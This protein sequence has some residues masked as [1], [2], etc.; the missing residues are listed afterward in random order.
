MCLLL[1]ALLLK[2]RK[3]RGQSGQG[4]VTQPHCYCHRLLARS[5][6]GEGERASTSPVSRAWFSNQ[7]GA[8]LATARRSHR[9]FYYYYQWLGQQQKWSR[10]KAKHAV[11]HT[12]TAQSYTRMT[13]LVRALSVT[14]AGFPSLTE[15]K[16]WLGLLV[17]NK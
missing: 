2:G 17:E 8:P 7:I 3:G 14:A 10:Q 11:Q 6:V 13:I 15:S 4:R 16:P 1:W 12:C 9:Y 5:G